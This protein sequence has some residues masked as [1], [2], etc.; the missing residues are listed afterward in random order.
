MALDI[1][2]P[3]CSSDEDLSGTPQGDG[4]IELTCAG[5][6]ISWMRDPRPRCP[7]C[8]GDDLYHRPQVIVEKSRGTQMSIQGVHVEYGCYVCDPPEVKVR[9][10]RSTHLPDRLG[11]SQ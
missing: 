3:R 4:T 7:D 5:C 6:R 9:G 11:G 10:G 2:C 8:G 1:V